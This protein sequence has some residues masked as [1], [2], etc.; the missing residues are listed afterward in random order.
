MANYYTEGSAELE[1]PAGSEERVLE[2]L[3]RVEKEIEERDGYFGVDASIQDGSLILMHDESLDTGHAEELV[4]ALQEELELD[5]P[6]MMTWSYS[7]SRPILDAF[8]GGGMLVQRGH[9][10]LYTDARSELEH[11]LRKRG[12][13]GPCGRDMPTCDATR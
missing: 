9:P 8:G 7:C 4:V 12:G 1:L 10:T 11:D 6:F 2:V 3:A 13:A 5:E